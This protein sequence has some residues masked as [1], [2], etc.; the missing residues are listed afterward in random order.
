MQVRSFKCISKSIQSHARPFKCRL[1]NES[2]SFVK[3]KNVHK[4]VKHPFGSQTSK[5]RHRCAIFEFAN[6]KLQKIT[7]KKN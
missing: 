5:F 2:S 6:K 4:D 7:N 3:T 1:G